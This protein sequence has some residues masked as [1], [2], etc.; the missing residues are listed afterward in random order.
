MSFSFAF[1]FPRYML[2]PVLLLEDS[3]PIFI[4]SDVLCLVIVCVRVTQLCPIL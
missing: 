2:V 3:E 4:P 1:L